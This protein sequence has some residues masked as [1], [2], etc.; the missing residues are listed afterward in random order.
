MANWHVVTSKKPNRIGEA[1]IMRNGKFVLKVYKDAPVPDPEGF[2]KTLAHL[3]NTTE[4]HGPEA[5]NRLINFVAG[6]KPA[7]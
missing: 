3:L 5:V 7:I 1:F 4:Q 6:S 2:A